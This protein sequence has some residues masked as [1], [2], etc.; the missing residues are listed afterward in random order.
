MLALLLS[1]TYTDLLYGIPPTIGCYSNIEANHD[2]M[3]YSTTAHNKA[4]GE[5]KLYMYLVG[6]AYTPLRENMKTL[7]ESHVGLTIYFMN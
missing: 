4:N 5:Y 3:S 1:Y 6:L 7:N 2:H